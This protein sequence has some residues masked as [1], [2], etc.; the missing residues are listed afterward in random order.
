MKNKLSE[1]QVTQYRGKCPWDSFVNQRLLCGL[2]IQNPWDNLFNL[3]VGGITKKKTDLRVHKQRRMGPRAVVGQGGERETA[4]VWP[5]ILSPFYDD[6]ILIKKSFHS[7]SGSKG[8]LGTLATLHTPCWLRSPVWCGI[9]S[10]ILKIRG[11]GRNTVGD[12]F[13]GKPWSNKR[14]KQRDSLVSTALSPTSIRTFRMLSCK[15]GR[16]RVR[17]ET[18]LGI[19]HKNKGPSCWSRVTLGPGGLGIDLSTARPGTQTQQS[20]VFDPSLS[21]LNNRIESQPGT[22]GA[23]LC[24]WDADTKLDWGKGHR[25]V[26][27]LG[28]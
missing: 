7:S 13:H 11:K 28:S 21:Y 12:N 10:Q 27:G 26:E 25:D 23:K 6:L 15:H 20:L 3:H 17:T 4:Q 2:V 18:F 19:K 9:I 8:R 14:D 5:K 1:S 16:W 24:S 22:W